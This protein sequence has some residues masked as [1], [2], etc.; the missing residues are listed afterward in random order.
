ML[1]LK[2]E[3]PPLASGPILCLLGAMMCSSVK[4]VDWDD[5]Q[6]SIIMSQEGE[7]FGTTDITEE[8]STR[9]Q[10]SFTRDMCE[11]GALHRDLRCT[12]EQPS[13]QVVHVILCRVPT[14]I[15]VSV[16][17][18]SHVVARSYGCPVRSH[19]V[20]RV[21]SSDSA[22]C[23]AV[24]HLLRVLL[25]G[26][27]QESLPAFV[28]MITMPFTFSIG[29]GIIAGLGLWISIQLLLAPL[30]LYRGESPM[31]RVRKLWGSAFVEGDEE[32]QRSGKG[33]PSTVT[34]SQ[35]FGEEV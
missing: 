22:L 25:R 35:S 13:S 23:E 17:V 27:F 26:G 5:F 12:Q 1:S 16:T 8:R 11:T 3:V 6:E 29:Y 15:P 28:A 19:R 10:Q 4:G 24:R 9:A 2:S 33:T 21:T 20:L 18:C 34:P 30:R 7:S 31:V 32:E 14:Y